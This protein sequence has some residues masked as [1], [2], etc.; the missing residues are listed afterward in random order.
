MTNRASQVCA[1][2]GTVDGQVLEIYGEI[3]GWGVTAQDVARELAEATGDVSVRCSSPGGD[4]F[5]GVAIMN[6]LRAHEGR[7]TGVV[8]GYAASAA[9]LVMVGG[10]DHLIM[11]PSAELMVH[12]AW[13]VVDGD[14]GELRRISDDLERMNVKMAEIYAAK[15]GSGVEMF[16]AAMERETWYSAEEALAVGLADEIRDGRQ[17]NAASLAMSARLKAAFRYRG[18]AHAPS[19]EIGDNMSFQAIAQRLGCAENADEATILAAL[20]E[21]LAERAGEAGAEVVEESGEVEATGE[22]VNESSQVEADL[23]IEATGADG[24]ENDAEDPADDAPTA[25]AAEDPLVVTIDAAA[26]EELR[27]KADYGERAR[28]RDEQAQR[29]EV[30]DQAIADNRISSAA[31]GRWLAAMSAD[32]EG[33]IDKLQRIPRDLIPRAEIGHSSADGDRTIKTAPRGFGA[34]HV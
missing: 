6:L 29:E 16:R 28:I 14:A 32:P 9:S 2:R 18:R 1:L 3:G 19:P 25:E 24:G 11:R 27:E 15:T 7:V 21:A 30:V 31:R 10:C 23:E 5:E 22:Q 26:L 33:T 20:D 17:V 8:E 12:N 13:T 4:V 34:V